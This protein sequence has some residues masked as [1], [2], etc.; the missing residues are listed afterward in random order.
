MKHLSCYFSYHFRCYLLVISSLFFLTSCSPHPSTGVWETA[1]ENE[2]GLS[3]LIVAF[4]GKAEFKSS[5]PV[6]A[7]W[8]CFWGKLDDQTLELD[9]TS[10]IN[11]DQARKFVVVSKEKLNAEFRE[12]GKLI[13]KL[14]RIDANPVLAE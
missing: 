4:E 8:H 12:N 2:L 1:S 13:A 14:K 7:N 10:S 9:C 6:E 11:T 5:K 3:E